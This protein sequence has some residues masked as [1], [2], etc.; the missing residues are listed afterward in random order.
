MTSIIIIVRVEYLAGAV[1]E[2][3]VMYRANNKTCP[4]TKETIK[5]VTNPFPLER[6]TVSSPPSQFC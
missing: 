6:L 5:S 4:T 1:V 3:I 2:S